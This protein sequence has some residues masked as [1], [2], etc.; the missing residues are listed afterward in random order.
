VPIEPVFPVRVNS[1]VGLYGGIETGGT[2]VGCIIGTGPDDVVA[3]TRFP[4]TTPVETIAAIVDF[5]RTQSAVRSLEAIGMGAFG[6]LDLDRESTTYG[7]VTNTPK[8]GWT[9]VDLCGPLAAGLQVPVT[10]DTDVNAAALGEY[11]WGR[12]AG[13]DGQGERPDAL[14][15][16]TVGTG[17]GVGAVIEGSPF[18][19]LLHPEAGHMRIPHD[20]GLDPFAGCCPFHK[21]CWEGLA[22]GRALE[23][24]WGQRAETL[25]PDHPA[26]ELEA[27][28]LGL[29]MANLICCFSPR[30]LVVGGGVLRRPGLLDRARAET[31]ALLGGYLGSDLLG[32]RIDRLIVPPSLGDRSGL[33]GA[34]ALAISRR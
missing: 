4:T 20:R 14:L 24:R 6:P 13:A 10:L 26:W 33:L 17:I 15:Y 11:L 27:H 21:D 3:E 16:L 2:T 28:Y 31:R 25:P 9:D 30:L 8:P 23:A 29:G 7:H 34:L 5:F 22:S 1:I 18:H 19:G 32:E 12:G